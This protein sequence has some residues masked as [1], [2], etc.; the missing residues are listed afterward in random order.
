MDIV[1]EK[2]AGQCRIA[3]SGEMTVYTAGEGREKLLVP[4]AGC[5]DTQIELDLA[6]VSDMDSA[7]QQLLIAA[8]ITSVARQNSLRLVNHSAAVR[9]VLDLYGLARYFGDPEQMPLQ[10]A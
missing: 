7:G 2:T 1:I 6:D 3:V 4:I 8:R 5:R 10:A 9:E